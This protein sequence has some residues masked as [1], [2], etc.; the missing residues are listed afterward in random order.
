MSQYPTDKDNRFTLWLKIAS[1][2]Y[3]RAISQGLTGLTPPS[4]NDDIFDL[5]KKV[6][7][8][9]AALST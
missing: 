5:Q 8:Y 9:T 7:Y 4:F 3:D 2:Y 1:N 6:T